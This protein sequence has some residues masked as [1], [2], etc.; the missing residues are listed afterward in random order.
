MKN[1]GLFPSFKEWAEG[2]GSFTCAYMDMGRLIYYVKGQ[3]EHHDKKTF[4][5]EYR[6]L[7]R[8][9]GITINER[10]FP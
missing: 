7:L 2:Y 1:S 4:E 6:S 9:S 10:Y 8:E 5:E 3:Q